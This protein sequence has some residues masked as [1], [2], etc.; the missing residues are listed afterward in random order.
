MSKQRG[1]SRK[2]RAPATGDITAKIFAPPGHHEIESLDYSRDGKLIVSGGGTSLKLWDVAT[3]REIRTFTGVADAI[4]SV[5]FSPDFRFVLTGCANHKAVL[6]DVETG[7]AIRSFIG[8]TKDDLIESV[9]FSPDGRSVLTGG[10]DKIIR[11]WDTASG[12][13]IRTFAGHTAW[14]NS[15]GF[16]P[17]GKYVFPEAG[18]ATFKLWDVATAAEIGPFKENKQAAEYKAA[19]DNLRSAGGRGRGGASPVAAAAP[20]KADV[21]PAVIVRMGDKMAWN[22]EAF[23]ESHQHRY[24]FSGR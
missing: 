5:V 6:W 12:Q 21:P 16:S 23:Q 9:A 10:S 8:Q 2:G 22:I 19:R 20:T 14:V 15:V 18:M 13:E 24:F 7:K 3:G 4:Y 1:L 17:D 11:L